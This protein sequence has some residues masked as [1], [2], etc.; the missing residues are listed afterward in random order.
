MPAPVEGIKDGVPSAAQTT[1]SPSWPRLQVHSEVNVRTANPVSDNTK[2]ASPLAVVDAGWS[3]GLGLDGEVG[4]LSSSR[5]RRKVKTGLFVSLKLQRLL[6]SQ[7]HQ[8][9]IEAPTSSRKRFRRSALHC[10]NA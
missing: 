10:M 5:A 6:D 1:A 8:A 4:T 7:F 2:R 3:R 9:V